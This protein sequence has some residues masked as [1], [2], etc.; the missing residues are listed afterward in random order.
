MNKPFSC[1]PRLCSTC[2][3]P[4]WHDSC[5]CVC[6]CL[7]DEPF[8]FNA[9]E[10]ECPFSL[11]CCWLTC[12]W[13]AYTLRL[14]FPSVAH[15]HTVHQIW[16]QNVN[17]CLFVFGTSLYFLCTKKA[18]SFLPSS[19]SPSPS[20]SSTCSFVLAKTCRNSYRQCAIRQRRRRRHSAT[21]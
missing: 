2:L 7:S 11:G 6:V 1:P 21:V 13:P 3:R 9:N 17:I 12:P 8:P 10:R 5:V 18:E 14:T 16:K 20:S 19:S 15:L 4:S